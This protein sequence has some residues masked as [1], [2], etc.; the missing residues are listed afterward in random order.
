M[1]LMDGEMGRGCEVVKWTFDLKLLANA[2]NLA[3]ND[4]EPAKLPLVSV[5]HP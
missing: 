1:A 2:F 5:Y 4:L 3:S